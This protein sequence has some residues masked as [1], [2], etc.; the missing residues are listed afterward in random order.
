M[1]DDS[2]RIYVDQLRDGQ[3]EELDEFFSPAFLDVDEKDLKFVDPVYIAGQAYLADD[4]LVLHLDIKT[5]A[6]IPCRICNN[7]VKI[8]IDLRGSY[9]AIPLN[10]IKTGIFDFREMLREAVLLEIPTLAECHQGNCPERQVMQNFFKKET[11]PGS[12]N[13]EDEGYRPFENLEFKD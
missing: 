4:M 6:C 10:E 2:F 13:G 5:F 9:F 8:N 11:V 12:H 3:V 1:I 7:A